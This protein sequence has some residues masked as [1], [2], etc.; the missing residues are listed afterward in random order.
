[1][2]IEAMCKSTVNYDQ[3]MYSIAMLTFAPF[4]Y[5]TWLRK[6]SGLLPVQIVM[7]FSH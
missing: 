4:S 5:S 2:V 1:M 3:S 7:P 6:P